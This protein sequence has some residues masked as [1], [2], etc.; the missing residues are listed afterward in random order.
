M[1]PAD[2]VQV[3]PPQELHYNVLTKCKANTSII[4]TPTYYITVW[5]TPQ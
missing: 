2:E 4:L 1:C 3:M 5:V